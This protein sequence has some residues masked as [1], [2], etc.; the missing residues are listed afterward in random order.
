MSY[1]FNSSPVNAEKSAIVRSQH[2]A[3]ITLVQRFAE[4]GLSQSPRQFDLL[5][6]LLSFVEIF[7]CQHCTTDSQAFLAVSQLLDMTSRQV[8]E[9]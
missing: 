4:D 5:R 7:V 6:S 8:S 2:L 3:V 9:L 1:L